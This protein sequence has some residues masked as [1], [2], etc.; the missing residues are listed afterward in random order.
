MAEVAE[1]TIKEEEKAKNEALKTSKPLDFTPPEEVIDEEEEALVT[2]IDEEIQ[3]VLK[4]KN[5]KISEIIKNR[6]AKKLETPRNVKVVGPVEVKVKFPP[7]TH[8]WGIKTLHAK[9][10]KLNAQLI[11]NKLP[12]VFKVSGHVK[13]DVEFP[14]VQ[15]VEV[16]FPETQ[17]VSGRVVAEVT[18]PETQKVEGTVNAGI[19]VIRSKERNG[20]DAVPVV[21]TD[22]K[23]LLS[24]F[25]QTVQ[26]QGRLTQAIERLSGAN[27]ES[28][29]SIAYSG[30]T[31]ILQFVKA[32]EGKFG[33]YYIDN[34][35]TTKIYV[36]IFLD[37]NDVILGTTM[38]DL[39]FGIP[40]GGAANLE[41]TRGRGFNQRA[42]I[43]ATVG[44]TGGAA[45]TTPLPATIYYS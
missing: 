17:K 28:W 20:I 38:A 14:K 41:L 34:P 18:F 9:M 21:F 22:L 19:P 36:Q 43:A 10:E 25:Q 1:T 2:D 16:K 11:K 15:K 37:K 26:G 33:G 4:D 27:N 23:K 39:I 31:N 24:P 44:P 45:P 35:N 12:D 6:I 3:Q 7:I 29:L 30:I 32:S 13:A 42:Q 8:V 5:N 40:A